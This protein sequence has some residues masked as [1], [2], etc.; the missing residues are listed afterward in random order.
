MNSAPN[1]DSKQC[2]ETKLGLVH[3]AHTHG[4]GCTRTAPRLRARRRVVA[5]T[6]PYHGPL[7]GRI[8]PVPGRVVAVPCHVAAHTRALARHVAAS[9]PAVSQPPRRDTESRFT[10]QL[11]SRTLPFVSQRPCTVS[12]GAAAPYRSLY[13]HD[14]I[15]CIL[16]HPCLGH[17]RARCRTP[18]AQAGRFVGRV[19]HVT[20]CIA[21]LLRPSMHPFGH[22]VA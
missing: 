12:Q 17:V 7:P 8:A 19:V 21:A 9:G 3:S 18:R 2:R 10:I 6:G 15:F 20:G 16:T 13:R 1:S 11:L 22:V 4:P 14:T 5:S